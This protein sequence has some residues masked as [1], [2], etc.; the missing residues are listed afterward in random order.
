MTKTAVQIDEQVQAAKSK[1]GKYLTFAFL[2]KGP[3]K[4]LE[5]EVVGWTQLEVQS[6]KTGNIKAVVHLWGYEVP[7]GSPKT[8]AGT[9][10][11]EMTDTTCIIIFEYSEPSK[12]Y[13]GMV[14]DAISNVMNIA[15]KDPE[16][17]AIVETEIVDEFGYEQVRYNIVEQADLLLLS[18]NTKE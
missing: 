1:E 9:D 7:V 13:L 4:K 18:A 16:I 12:R 15:E 11:G 6:N 2:E 10:T 5:L 14:V 17:S 3:D 8:L